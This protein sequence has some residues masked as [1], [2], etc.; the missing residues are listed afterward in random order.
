MIARFTNWLRQRVGEKPRRTGVSRP[1][2][3]VAKRSRRAEIRR[4]PV[5][6]ALES[7]CLLAFGTTPP[8]INLAVCVERD[9]PSRRE[10]CRCAGCQRPSLPYIL[11]VRR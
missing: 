10:R 7:R 5:I 8:V 1:R 9:Q 3:S 6:E 4:Q 11:D 2:R